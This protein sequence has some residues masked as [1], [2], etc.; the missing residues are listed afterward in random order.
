MSLLRN[1]Q[2]I[3]I[4][5]KLLTWKWRQSNPYKANIIL[6]ICFYISQHSSNKKLH[7]LSKESQINTA[8]Y[9]KPRSKIW[10]T[11]NT[12]CKSI[13]S[14]QLRTVKDSLSKK[15]KPI[16]VGLEPTTSGSEVQRAIHCATRP[17]L[18]S[19]P[20]FWLKITDWD[21]SI[22]TKD[23]TL[24]KGQASTWLWVGITSRIY[25]TGKQ[26]RLAIEH[27]LLLSCFK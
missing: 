15:Q 26:R 9:C 2:F 17:D 20:H 23:G 24:F 16:E 10:K 27:V 13:V 8:I 3:K 14:S 21:E 5:V 22:F 12:W 18:N 19:I 6:S 1:A 7:A 11:A 25:T 4:R